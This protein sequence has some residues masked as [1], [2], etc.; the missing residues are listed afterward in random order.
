MLNSSRQIVK[1]IKEICAENSI[2]LKLFSYDW[3]MQLEIGRK[4]TFIYGYQFQNNN[5][6][7]QLICDDK[8]ALSDI[9][10][11]NGINAVKHHFFMSPTNMAYVGAAGNWEKMIKLLNAY[12]TIVCKDNMGTSGNGVY[13]AANQYELENAVFTI[14]RTSRALSV[15]K[16][17]EIE[18]EY[19]VIVL[20]GKAELIYSK[21]IP[22]VTGDGKRKFEDLCF[23]KYGAMIT[24]TSVRP[25]E[26]I[27]KD[28]M[29]KLNWK[30]N[31]DKGA[32]A[33]IVTDES[34][35]N[36]LSKLALAAADVVNIKFASVDIIKTEGEYKVLEI[37]SG[38]MMEN[39]AKA[40]E[41][42]Y[43]ISKEIYTKALGL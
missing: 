33:I 15:C 35:K 32:S 42:N 25:D 22:F 20:N 39:F 13:M 17:Y 37:N 19:R 31:L 26:V 5:G 34:I 18:N 23:E 38:I 30:H 12:G 7:S 2:P 36:N 9:L 27:S 11:E 21:E 41:K 28:A 16:Y 4:N 3:I 29:V 43:L 40:S 8:S 24:E 14:F 1:I 6:T 10:I